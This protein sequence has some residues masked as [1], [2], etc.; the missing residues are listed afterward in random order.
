MPLAE[1][2]VGHLRMGLLTLF[3][4]VGFVL[5]IACANV[6][7]MFLAR[8]SVRQKE[9]AIRAALGAGQ[10]RLIRQMLTESL[11]LSILGGAVG[12]LLALLGVKALV[13]FVFLP[14]RTCWFSN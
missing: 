9:L 11:L 12:L 4:S 10:K 13:V 2:L 5:L 8:A 3:G 14:L 6:A 7:N 1:R